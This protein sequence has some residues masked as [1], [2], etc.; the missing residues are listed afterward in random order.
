VTLRF[1]HEVRS[2]AHYF[3]DIPEMKLPGE[4]VESL[5][6]IV[7]PKSE[8]FDP[9]HAGESSPQRACAYSAKETGEASGT[10]GHS[11]TDLSNGG[12]L[13]STPCFDD[14]GRHRPAASHHGNIALNAR[15][16]ASRPIPAASTP[17]SKPDGST[18]RA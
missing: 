5:Q 9:L 18:A 16:S 6:H 3:S 2:E 1:A 11:Q 13:K 17:R 4:D 15:P 14:R 8:E 7:R 12:T 10:T